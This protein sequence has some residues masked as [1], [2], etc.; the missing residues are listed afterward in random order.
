MLLLNVPYE[1]KDEAK[2]LGAKWNSELKKWYIQNTK[3]C[4]KFMKWI[5]KDYKDYEELY[6]LK[7]HLYIAEGIR[8]CIISRKSGQKIQKIANLQYYKSKANYGTKKKGISR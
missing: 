3:D 6:I 1:E 8:I 2:S 4:G 5:W 7:D